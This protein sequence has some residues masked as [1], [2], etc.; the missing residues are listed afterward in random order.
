MFYSIREILQ[1][2]Q[3]HQKSKDYPPLS[4]ECGQPV[5]LCQWQTEPQGHPVPSIATLPE[6]VARRD[7]VGRVLV[8]KAP[9]GVLWHT[10]GSSSVKVAVP[11]DLQ[12]HDST[13]PSG[14]EEKMSSPS[15]QPAQ[16]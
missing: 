4:E 10:V 7:S 16:H 13:L 9:E 2:L 15:T 6:V 3:H 1:V 12:R 8:V 11:V 5:T 14:E